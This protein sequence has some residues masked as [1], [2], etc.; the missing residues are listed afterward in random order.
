MASGLFFLDIGNEG[1]TPAPSFILML[2]KSNGKYGF[3]TATEKFSKLAPDVEASDFHACV[4]NLVTVLRTIS[5][6]ASVI[7]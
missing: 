4:T 6:V 2:F 5:S 3:I 1:F 7:S